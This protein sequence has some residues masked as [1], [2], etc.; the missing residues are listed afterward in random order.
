MTS[1]EAADLALP[2]GYVGASRN[3]SVVGS[4]FTGEIH[5]GK[6]AFVATVDTQD[7]YAAVPAQEFTH[8]AGQYPDDA[9]FNALTYNHAAGTIT[10]TGI[11]VNFD[12]DS[13]SALTIRMRQDQS[14]FRDGF[15]QP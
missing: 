4:R 6:N 15:E 5:T 1:L 13:S 11:V 10:A 3:L 8:N 9:G 14:V 12:G 7:M 2:Q